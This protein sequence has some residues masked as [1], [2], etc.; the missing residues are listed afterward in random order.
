MVDAIPEDVTQ[1]S[2]APLMPADLR[3]LPRAEAMPF[4]PSASCPVCRVRVDPLRAR[5]VLA[6]E[7]GF[8]YFCGRDCLDTYR[9]SEPSRRLP[10][11]THPSEKIGARGEE[12]VQEVITRPQL[13]SIPSTFPSWVPW[14]VLPATALGFWPDDLVRAVSALALAGALLVVLMASRVC[15]VDSTK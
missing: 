5:T 8:R 2:A 13:A 11:V 12:L 3:S 1:V 6:L 14:L 7:S 15:K 4:E 9:T 10:V